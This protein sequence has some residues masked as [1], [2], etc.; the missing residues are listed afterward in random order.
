MATLEELVVK[1]S[2]D[3]DELK[4]QL[5][6]ATKI[7]DKA[8]KD[9]QKAITEFS[10]KSS[11]K[12]T[13]FQTAMATMTG[14]LGGAAVQGAFN[15][16]K[17][18]ASFLSG[19]LIEG[20]KSAMA[21]EQAL[22]RLGNALNASGKY[23]QKAISDLGS[24]ADEMERLTGIN[25]DVVLSNLSVLSSITRLNGEGLKKAQQAAIELSAAMGIDLDS[26]T[27][28]VGKAIEGNG[29]ALKRYGIEVQTTSDKTQNL[30]NVTKSLNE[31]F[32][33]A[34]AAQMNTFGGALK[35]MQNAWGNV[36]EAVSGAVTGNQVFISVLKSITQVF[37]SLEQYV[38]DNATA[39]RDG[40]GGA[41]VWVLNAAQN[42]M[43][44]FSG[45]FNFLNAGFQV[46]MV[47]IRNFI[48]QIQLLKAAATLDWDGVKEN[49]SDI[50]DNYSKAF[51]SVKDI[52]SDN[53]FDTIADKIGEIKDN[54]Q[55]A[56]EKM[57]SGSETA[58]VGIKQATTATVELSEA[59]KTHNEVIKS[60]TE[61]LAS[62]AT[63]LDNNYQYM[64][65][66]QAGALELSMAA[67][68]DD[69][70]AQ[71]E[72][73]NAFFQTKAEMAAAQFELEQQALVDARAQ[74]LSTEQ[75]YADA[76]VALNQKRGVDMQKSAIEQTKY[77]QATQ[78]TR[79]ANFKSSMATI[80]T[81]SESGNKE[82]AA[83]GKAAAIT[84]ATI[85]GY[86]AVQKALASAPP[87]FNFALA[88]VVG[89]AAAA[90]VA[91]IAGVGFNKGTDSVP[92]IG[93]TDSVPAMLT[94]GE[95][96]VPQKT[97]QDLTA[98]LQNQG[99][100]SNQTVNL[101]I[102][103]NIAPGTGID[104]EQAATIVE[105]INNYIAAGGLKVI[106]A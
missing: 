38:T 85:D 98:F 18:A 23:T 105:G 27:R 52:N 100:G 29:A 57:Q 46:L 86:Q 73:Q 97:N 45:L 22:A 87:P 65:A 44:A 66:I 60:F 83:I 12:T 90:N 82:L 28:L 3:T 6:T 8:A 17:D 33:G 53:S 48:D 15:A 14:F 49:I 79:E 77:D 106:G 20:A 74:G 5:M 89:V 26:A 11:Q 69:F 96:V 42:T 47:P 92:G 102:T 63:A 1:L 54:A 2:A 16:V 50:G 75:Q 94:P 103:M 37:Q 80:A 7:T 10:D 34:A 25:D 76:V 58:A 62:Q 78:K 31:K 43:Y 13:F 9:M 59:Q 39:I 99:Q 4:S 24:F 56:F 72:L 30:A 71:V 40:L 95:R 67:V 91:K 61:G 32:G 70:N 101:N 81:L 41:L 93:S 84:N 55:F 51:Q 19:E 64:S 68:E 35:G 36:T 88:A 21:Q 104:R